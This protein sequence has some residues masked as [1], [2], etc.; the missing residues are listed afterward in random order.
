ME[1]RHNLSMIFKILLRH[2]SSSVIATDCSNPL[3]PSPNTHLAPDS[4]VSMH[5]LFFV[6]DGFLSQSRRKRIQSFGQIH[7]SG[8]ILMESNPSV[9]EARTMAKASWGGK[10]IAESNATVVVEGNQYFPPAAVKRELL[11]PSNHTTV[12]P[13]KGTAHYYHVEVNGIRNDNAAWYYPEPKPAA[14]EIKDRIA[15]W[16]GVRVEA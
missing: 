1:R 5:S 15:F 8:D 16:K 11:K 10:V 9:P 13:W 14:A 7:L 4:S 12:C 2:C 3:R 6:A